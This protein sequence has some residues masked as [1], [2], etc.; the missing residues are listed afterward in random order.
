[1]VFKYFIFKVYSHSYAIMFKLIFFLLMEIIFHMRIFDVLYVFH[2]KHL[3]VYLPDYMWIIFSIFL[4]KF[5][6]TINKVSGDSHTQSTL[7][8]RNYLQR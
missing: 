5:L 3:H 8:T 7:M 4:V 1:M 2:F 6:T